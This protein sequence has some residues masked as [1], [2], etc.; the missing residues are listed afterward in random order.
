M[1]EFEISSPGAA[2]RCSVGAFW[3]FPALALRGFSDCFDIGKVLRSSGG[4]FR[5][6]QIVA[7]NES[8]LQPAC[9]VN[10]VFNPARP[11]RIKINT[12]NRRKDVSSNRCPAHAKEGTGFGRSRRGPA[13]E[14]A[15]QDPPGPRKPP[16]RSPGWPLPECR[17]LELPA[18]AREWRRR[19][20]TTRYLTRYAFKTDK[21]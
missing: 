16:S 21:S 5:R 15:R 3:S 14:A 9:R 2:S 20:S 10:N 19:S 8:R 18:V 12:G 7:G 17:G 11:C 1:S 4:G 6:D 13:L